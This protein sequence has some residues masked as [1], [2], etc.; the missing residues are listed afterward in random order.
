VEEPDE[1][2]DAARREVD[3]AMM[4]R[5]DLFVFV[6]DPKE[7]RVDAA[8]PP[9]Q[10][11]VATPLLVSSS[12]SSSSAGGEA[13]ACWCPLRA[14]FSGVHRAIAAPPAGGPPLAY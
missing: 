10:T 9:P 7:M 4:V 8:P 13:A 3:H 2:E 11:I 6:F 14:W 5:V 12:S 1:R